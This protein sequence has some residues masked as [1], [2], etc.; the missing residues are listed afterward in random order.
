[1]SRLLYRLGRAAALRPWRFIV[2][3]LVLVAAMAGL[4][5]V[6]GGAL[7]DN[8]TLAGTGSQRATDLLQERFPAL[9][10]ADARVVVHARSGKVDQA[11]LAAAA[12]GL[13]KLPHVS[14]VDPAQFGKG[15]ATALMTVRYSVPVTD[16]GPKETLDLLRS[17]TRNLDA[18]GYQVEF[19]GQ[20]PENVTAP[21]GVAEAVGIV[22]ALV[23]LLLAFGSVVAAGL[24]LAVA[25]AGLGVGVSGI[26]LVAAFTDVA[27]TAPTLATMV[28]LGVGID[29]AL[30]VLTR[31]RE[32]LAEGLDVP[33]AVGRAIATAGLSVIF[34]GF[35]VLLALCGLVLSRIP[36]FMTMG[37]TTG[38]VV[39]ATVL[40]AV[41]LLPAVLGL[42]GRRVLRRRDRAAGATIA[43]ESPR[44][45]RWA[46]HVG[47]HP[48]PWLLAAAVLMLTLAAPALGMRTWPSD[49]SSEPTS[50]TVR[51]AYDLVADGFGAGAN[52][53]LAVAVDLTGTDRAALPGLR[54]RLEGVEGVA[55][56]A[57]PQL[58]PRG[59]AAV[60]MVTPDYGPQD[61][62]VTGLVDRIRADVLPP[63]TEVTGLTAVYVD[64]S[65]VL[66]DRLWPVIGVVVA[67][68]FIMLMIVFRSLLAPLKAAVMNLLSIGAAYGVLTAVFQ[69]GW[70]AELLGLPHSVPVSSFILLLMF[71]VLFGVSMDYEVFLLSRVREE[72]L[73]H[74]DA[75]GSVST[76]LAATGRV[77]SSAALIMVAVFLGFAADPGLVIKQMGVGLAVAVALDATVVRLVLVPA[78]MSLL[79]RANWWLPGPLA[80]VLPAIDLHGGAA[81]APPAERRPEP[82]RA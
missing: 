19:G 28:G 8:Y 17:A 51:Q 29:Y 57:P 34:A 54:D 14:G 27:T 2:V 82:S 31:H 6:A 47:R 59:D 66:S 5:G 69:W 37:F 74:G 40:S 81:P 68:S 18:A 50:N 73:L 30:F 35:T 80:R 52:G 65:R 71:A 55:S 45:R 72:W 67:T 70:G 1:M 4:S 41:T 77:I 21:G 7:H 25:L 62:R 23:I 44:V 38:I 9:A 24:P 46:L 48:W 56:V 63:D 33:E 11:E 76:G 22:A 10:G 26:T 58:S 32:G 53:P 13:R 64:L 16:L 39:A 78:T 43:V 79:G 42:A 49:A 61:E 20:V 36:V 15:G 3:W 75:R 60:I 12:T